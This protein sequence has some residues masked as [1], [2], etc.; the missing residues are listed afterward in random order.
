M[1]S[2][3]PADQAGVFSRATAKH[4]TIDDDPKPWIHRIAASDTVSRPG[5]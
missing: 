2:V 5:R 4:S 1:P 3:T